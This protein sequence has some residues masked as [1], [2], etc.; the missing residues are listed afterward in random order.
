M[1]PSQTILIGLPIIVVIFVFLNFYKTESAEESAIASL[2]CA[3]AVSQYFPLLCSWGVTCVYEKPPL[4]LYT[5]VYAVVGGT[6]AGLIGNFE[7]KRRLEPYF[8]TEQTNGAGVLCG[9][10]CSI[11]VGLVLLKYDRIIGL[12]VAPFAA[13]LPVLWIFLRM[14]YEDWP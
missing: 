3:L 13:L 11:S 6:S 12:P 10:A 5:D 14:I 9:L 1:I 2:A 4:A 7:T 8:E